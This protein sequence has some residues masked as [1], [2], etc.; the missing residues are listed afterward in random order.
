MTVL[1]STN[2]RANRR[3]A[4]SSCNRVID[5]GE[6]YQS[7][8]IVYDGSRY[9]YKSC[10]QCSVIASWFWNSEHSDSWDDGLDLGEWLN[11]VKGD[12]LTLARISVYFHRQWRRNDGT[13][14]DA[15]TLLPCT[16]K[17]EG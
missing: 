8:V 14:V 17:K 11:H 4:C 10:E 6:K 13:F 15:T 2:P 5:I 16:D 3:H 1:R 7:D 9:T 12:S